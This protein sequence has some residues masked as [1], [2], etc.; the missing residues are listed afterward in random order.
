MNRPVRPV[1][2][3]ILTACMLYPGVALLYQ[4]IYPFVSGEWFNLKG[5]PGLWKVFLGSFGVPMVAVDL[6]KAA[7]GAAWMAGVLGLWA[8]DGRAYPLT[9][10]AASLTLLYPGGGMV[11][12]VLGLVCLVFFREKPDEGIA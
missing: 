9:L 7:L 4:G 3:V 2:L 8:G 10:L 11:M 12:A 5:D 1:A 6:L